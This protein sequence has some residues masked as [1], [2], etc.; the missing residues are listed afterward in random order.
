VKHYDVIVVGG[1]H[2]G[3]EAALAA[4]R[5][6]V[7]VALVTM[8]VT[9]IGVMSCN[10]AMGGLGKGHLIREIDALDGIMGR[11][12]DEAGIQFRLLNRSKG[13]AVQG[14]RAQVDRALYRSFAQREVAAVNLR[15]FEGEVV[16]LILSGQTVS[17]VRLAEG[18]DLYGTSVVLTMGTFLNGQIH[19]G[20]VRSAGGRL[21]D[22]PS[23]RLAGQMGDLGLQRGRLKTGTPPRLD[24]KSIDWSKVELQNGD[25]VPTMLSFL[26]TDVSVPQVPCGISST[27]EQTH[28]IIRA[29]ITKSAMYGGHVEGVGPRYCPSIE[30]K[31]V[32]FSDKTSHQVYL[33]PESL[34]DD[35][36]YPNGVSTSLPAEIQ[37][38][39]V[40]SIVGLERARIL[41]PG[42]AIEYD[43]YDPRCLL[44]SLAVRDWH[45]L[46]FAGQINGTTGYEEAA[47]QG[48]AA[49][50]N[51]ALAARDRPPV[52]FSRTN[53]YIGVLIDD[54]ITKGI[55]EPY[56][57]FTS[58]AEF[59]LS[60][61]ADN[62]DQR[63]TAAGH[64]V[65]CVSEERWAV[66]SQ[67]LE[68]VEAGRA[69]LGA[70]A[71]SPKELGAAGI[72]V[73]DEGQR[74]SMFV[75]LG[76]SGVSIEGVSSLVP[77]FGA[78]PY[79]VREQIAIEALYAPYAHRQMADIAALERDQSRTIPDGFSYG[80]L[81]GLSGEL[82]AKLIALR[83]RSLAHA[84]KI[85]GMTPAALMLILS[86][87]RAAEKQKV[88]S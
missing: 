73:S 63:L 18:Q 72:S 82:T 44:G 4:A 80:D 48:L 46:Y 78:L 67:K 15:C 65:G 38:L 1:G 47:A 45:G 14:P 33:E 74:R 81:S 70:C 6:G 43:Y 66:F 64:D 71:L 61:R 22:A 24:G 36:V 40:R 53:S 23:A 31:V 19:V 60:L 84:S 87:L 56:R 27:N 30:D 42:Y 16:E 54:L 49:G 11:G 9:G 29:N 17:G 79:P 28:E 3:I 41:Q 25:E 88:A 57:M 85:E 13:P 37:E 58:R 34:T 68:M 20:S 7:S 52:E 8:K 39:Y 62:A 10:P 32:R 2:A 21:G 69:A 86:R 5:C 51:A 55:T 26:S 76:L 83:P 12:A 35:V 50:L 59:R 75:V 77:D